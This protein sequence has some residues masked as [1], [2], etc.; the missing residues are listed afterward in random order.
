MKVSDDKRMHK[1]N[2]ENKKPF[3]VGA[4][5]YY[6]IRARH[7]M[8]RCVQSALPRAFQAGL[9]ASGVIDFEWVPRTERLKMNLFGSRCRMDSGR[10]AVGPNEEF[11]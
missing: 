1:D 9:T 8:E 5:A 4:V 2:A 6:R 10:R 3:A 7:A 11:L